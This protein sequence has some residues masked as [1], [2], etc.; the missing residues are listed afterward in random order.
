LEKEKNKYLTAALADD[1]I[2]NAEEKAKTNELLEGDHDF[3]NEYQ[4]QIQIKNLIKQKIGFQKI[5]EKE[6]NKII[7]K[8]KYPFWKR[9]FTYSKR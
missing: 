8:I 7:K 5:S 2:K 9:L 6:R 3:K 4:I 1:E